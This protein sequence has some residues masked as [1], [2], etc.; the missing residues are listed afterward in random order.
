MP[1]SPSTYQ[2]RPYHATLLAGLESSQSSR[3]TLCSRSRSWI[4]A[5]RAGDCACRG[6][7]LAD[8]QPLRPEA[9]EFPSVHLLICLD[10]GCIRPQPRPQQSRFGSL[11]SA[12]SFCE[13]F[14]SATL[15]LFE[16]VKIRHPHIYYSLSL[17]ERVE[18]P[19]SRP[20]PHSHLLLLQREGLLTLGSRSAA[21][22]CPQD[23]P[24][25]VGIISFVQLPSA[26]TCPS[27]IY[28][29][30]TGAWLVPFADGADKALF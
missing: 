27:V 25:S 24:R 26:H 8:L 13:L 29:Y 23:R 4:L 30:W 17:E 14:P 15:V 12:P 7:T 10:S 6:S 20:P 11:P 2:H 16:Q 21:V 22:I 9:L 1:P 28:R 18:K 5:D 19:L 3:L